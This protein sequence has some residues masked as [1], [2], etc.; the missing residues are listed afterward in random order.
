MSADRRPPP[1][2]APRER[3]RPRALAAGWFVRVM[4]RQLFNSL[5]LQLT[6][7]GHGP[8]QCSHLQLCLCSQIESTTR[9]KSPRPPNCN[10]AKLLG[11]RLAFLASLDLEGTPADCRCDTSQN[12]WARHRQAVA[13]R[14]LESCLVSQAEQCIRTED[15][16][17]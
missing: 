1:S 8:G 2:I 16:R 15:V 12:L 9:L 5:D 17:H 10:V 11:R 7:A 4:V 6:N 14:S 3:Q 13:W